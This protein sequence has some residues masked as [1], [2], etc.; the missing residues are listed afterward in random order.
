LQHVA[1]G[2]RGFIALCM[3]CKHGRSGKA[4]DMTVLV[5]ALQ[6]LHYLC[7]SAFLK[8]RKQPS[9]RPA[10][11]SAPAG[12]S[13]W[14]QVKELLAN[15]DTLRS[16]LH[17]CPEKRSSVLCRLK[18]A[19]ALFVGRHSFHSFACTKEVGYGDC[20]SLNQGANPRCRASY[21][22]AVKLP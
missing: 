20:C 17:V 21:K 12:A 5:L 13:S 6:G 15:D 3:N 18:Q 9:S 2:C 7:C 22:H 14:V 1:Q 19:L 11:S 4:L 16:D 10:L 8:R